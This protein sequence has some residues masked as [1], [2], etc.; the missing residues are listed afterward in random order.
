MNSQT[1]LE[2]L[3][4]SL[5]DA[6]MTAGQIVVVV[7]MVLIAALDGYDVQAMSFVAPV[8]SKAWAI[9]K[10]TL[11]M[12]LGASLFGMAG[13]AIALSPFADIYG[14]R[15][16]VLTGLLLMTTG[17]MM[18]ALSGTTWELAVSRVVTGLGIGVMVSLTTSIAAEF[19]S[20][21]RRGLAVA[22]T[23]VGV[24][25]GGVVGG[26]VT[27]GILK[28]HDWHWVFGIGSVAGVM[29]LLAATR[30][31]ESPAFLIE[32][33]PRNA[34]Q[35][36]NRVLLQIGQQPLTELPQQAQ[37]QRG[38]YR[39]LFSGGMA[40]TTVRLA[41]VFLLVTT[42]TYY[43]IS[44]LPQ[45][46]AD[47]GFPPSTASVVAATSSAVGI[48]AGLIFGSLAARIGPVKLTGT[49]I[50]GFGI[51]LAALGFVPAAL[52]PLLIAASACGFFLSAATAVF[53]AS[54]TESFPPLMRVSGIG[55][56]MGFGR[57]LSGVGPFFA[58]AM[59]AAGF[60]R[61]GVSLVFAALAVVAGLL[62]LAPLLVRRPSHE[63]REAGESSAVR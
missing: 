17:S 40:R 13:G 26:L 49:A 57:L 63:L 56:V 35:R 44:W 8:V 6:P 15:P 53:Y 4:G 51:S 24:A 36:L 55:F 31:P 16:T 5:A 47:A 33:R 28:R 3:R 32:R 2:R 10:A 52:P 11:G 12:L 60:G 25:L 1:G 54:L 34:L 39:A 42:A 37:T 29:L 7:L 21:R 41:V 61:S 18:S 62:M 50:I 46:V 38:S 27:A 58:G 20:K 14:R 43:L 48:A 22:S 45:L 23:S 19:S 59:F 30:L 9:D